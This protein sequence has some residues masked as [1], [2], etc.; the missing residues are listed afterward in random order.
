M[1]PMPSHCLQK[2]SSPLLYLQFRM[3]ETNQ[4]HIN[5]VVNWNY[6]VINLICITVQ[7]DISSLITNSM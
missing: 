6:Q 5:K 3:Q 4:Q 2:S 7:N 1:P